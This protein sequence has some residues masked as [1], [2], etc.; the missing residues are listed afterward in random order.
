[1]WVLQ[2]ILGTWQMRRFQQELRTL[3]KQGR[4]AVGRAHGRFWAGAVV[5][6]CIDAD[7]RIQRGRIMEGITNFARFQDFTVFDGEDLRCLPKADGRR[8]TR[9]EKKA[10]LSAVADYEGYM[11][12]HRPAAGTMPAELPSMK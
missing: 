1:M 4:V 12:E 6:F 2:I 7:C 11:A 5:F 8:L 10:V 9:T 3:R